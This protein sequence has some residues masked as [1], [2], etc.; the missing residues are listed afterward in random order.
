M[1]TLLKFTLH[2]EHSV[3]FVGSA[4]TSGSIRTEL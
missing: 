1:D 2:V 3:G 4:L